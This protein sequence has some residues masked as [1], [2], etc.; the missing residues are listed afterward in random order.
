MKLEVSFTRSF[1]LWLKLQGVITGKLVM[2]QEPD[3]L[4]QAARHVKHE[5]FHE[6]RLVVISKPQE[7]PSVCLEECCS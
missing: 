6:C 4:L 5:M 3:S 2:A 7:M 1:N